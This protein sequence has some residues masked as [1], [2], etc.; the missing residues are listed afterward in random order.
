MQKISSYLYPNRIEL[1]ADLAGFTT[2]YTNVYQRIVKIY[3]GVDNVIE[4]DVKNADQK[5]INIA[6]SIDNMRVN[7]MDA[8]GNEIGIY[9]VN[10]YPQDGVKKG[11]AYFTIN[12]DSLS[13][14]SHQFLTYSVT[15]TVNGNPQVLYGDTRFGAVGT[16]ELVG[17]AMP[18]SRTD[19]VYNTFTAEIDLNG[20]PTYHSSAIPA[21]F[22]EAVK[23]ETLSFDVALKGFTGSVWLEATKQSTLNTEAW[24]GA[25]YVDSYTFESFTGTWSSTNNIIGD[26]KYFRIS[27]TT[28]RS[29]GVGASFKVDTEDNVYTV[30]IRAGGTGYAVGSQIKVLGSSMG[31]VDGINDLIITVTNIDSTGLSSYAISSINGISTSGT[32]ANGTR[33]YIVTGTNITGTVDKVTVS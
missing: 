32:A 17:N 22:Y 5:R 8:S 21:T 6:T 26:N 30:S 31:G 27:Y 33:T 4:L 29:N 13:G 2:E 7:L 11:L 28:P 1:L 10:V 24:K 18:T 25:D 23:T 9:E 19:R 12:A 16:I 14:L 15:H 20:H 3:K